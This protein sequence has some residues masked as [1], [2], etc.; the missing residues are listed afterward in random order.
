[1]LQVGAELLSLAELLLLPV[2]PLIEPAEQRLEPRPC[3][4]LHLELLEQR[5]LLLTRLLRLG[6]WLR[7]G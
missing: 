2:Q 3:A 5:L 6:L 4:L 1:M 7:F